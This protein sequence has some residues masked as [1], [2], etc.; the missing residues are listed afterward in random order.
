M[1]S[2]IETVPFNFNELY[3]EI[4]EQFYNAG[5]DIA[6]GSNT[7]Q[8]MTA[9]AYLV[10]MLNVN[11]ALNANELILSYATKR[12]NV[13][14]DA[15]NLGYEPYHMTSYV[16]NL[17]CTNN[18]GSDL[19]VPKY[20]QFT[21]SGH[22]YYYFGSQMRITA[23]A[24]VTMQV[25]EGTLYRYSDTSTLEVIIG[26]TYENGQ[27]VTQ[28]YI[29]IP[30]TNVEDDGIECYLTYYDSNNIYQDKEV[31]LKS[32]DVFFDYDADYEKLFFRLD[33]ITYGTPRIYFKYA[34][35]GTDVAEG[36]IVQLNVLTTSGP[37][38]AIEDGAT[39]SCSDILGLTVDEVNLVSIGQDEESIEN[40]QENAP[41][42][43]NSANRMVVAN[44]YIAACNR[45]SRVRDTVVWGGEDEFPKAPGHIWFTFL[46]SLTDESNVFTS[47]DYNTEYQ[48]AHASY[49]WNY[50]GGT[51]EMEAQSEAREEYYEYN[52]LSATSIRSREYNSDG[53]IV[54]PGIWDN[55]DDLKIPTLAFHNRHPIYINFD[56]E[57]GILKYEANAD[58]PTVHQGVFD[59]I[60]NAFMGISDN[61]NYESFSSEYFNASI[62]KRIDQQ[63][64]DI[65]GFTEKVKMKLVLNPKTVYVEQSNPLYRDIYIP[66]AVPYEN[67]F[68]ENGVLIYDNLP[69]IDTENFV[70]Y[71]DEDSGDLFV[72]W[73]LIQADIDAGNTQQSQKLI[74]APIRIRYKDIY[75]FAD[76]PDDYTAT[77]KYPLYPD[78]VS[79]DGTDS[80][81]YTFDHVKVYWRKAGQEASEDD[82]LTYGDLVY[83]WTYD[84][85]NPQRVVLSS[86]I[87]FSSDDWL[88]VE[89]ESFCGFYYL[90]NSFEKE[91]LIHL[92]VDC[93][94]S[95]LEYVTQGDYSSLPAV[96]GSEYYL[97]TYDDD[98]LY[99]TDTYYLVTEAEITQ[100]TSYV[101][102]TD[103][104][105]R[106]YLYTTDMLYLYTPDEYYLTT[107]GYVAS[108][109]D[110]ETVYS[111]PTIRAINSKMYTQ[112]ALKLDLFNRERYLNLSYP[113]R[114]FKVLRNVIPRLNSVTFVD[115]IN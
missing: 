71:I 22:S 84:E 8:L 104:T 66:L 74:I 19:I 63:V 33:N 23:G 109:S 91:I 7:S 70:N 89:S 52:Y 28:Y 50:L 81:A 31:W 96:E 49:E 73:S 92:F 112:S 60:Y 86:G 15:R 20:T 12:E 46:P 24:T 110:D 94:A 11:T 83:G 51:E 77:L 35:A 59:I 2:V 45:D 68:D 40:I 1:A 64:T 115:L 61:V 18:S 99:T 5:Y 42:W 62:I 39:V 55:I 4:K 80:A 79:Q 58:Q 106:S 9:Q 69:S 56:Y 16:Y 67:Y 48:R 88:E 111:G 93:D 17:T 95:G 13:L 54:N 44:D 76:H 25:K 53:T 108:S 47:D 98:Y 3:T 26:T 85:N 100:D 14:N 57:I 36:T 72:D 65:T 113:S 10:S 101:G 114:N 38:G 105:P 102:T 107:N 75:Y 21:A 27:E 29:D 78:L 37:D 6:E 34:G 82:L 90:F 32:D 97:Y 103:T 87:S 43:Y 30:Y 41:K